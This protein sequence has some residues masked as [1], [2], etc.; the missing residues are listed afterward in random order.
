MRQCP[1]N[2]VAD[3]RSISRIGYMLELA[4]AAVCHMTAHRSDMTRAWLDNCQTTFKP[5]L[6]T[7]CSTLD[8]TAIGCR[9][10]ATRCEP[11]DESALAPSNRFVFAHGRRCTFAG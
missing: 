1:H 8:E 11:D 5:H 9:P 3:K 4:T 2:P 10:I 6:V 7:H